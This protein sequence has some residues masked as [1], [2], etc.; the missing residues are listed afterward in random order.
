MVKKIAK[1]VYLIHEASQKNVSLV[2]LVG[3]A[4]DVRRSTT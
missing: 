1:V 4:I 2:F 3:A